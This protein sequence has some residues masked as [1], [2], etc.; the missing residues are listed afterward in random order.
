[1]GPL[2]CEFML[3]ILYRNLTSTFFCGTTR[4]T[5]QSGPPRPFPSRMW[6]WA[7]PFQNHTFEVTNDPAPMA[8]WS[9]THQH[10]PSPHERYGLTK[11]M[12]ISRHSISASSAVYPRTW[13]ANFASSQLRRIRVGQLRTLWNLLGQFDGLADGVRPGLDGA[14]DRCV[15]AAAVALAGDTGGARVSEML[16]AGGGGQRGLRPLTLPRTRQRTSGVA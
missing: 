11:S 10:V 2:L 6:F 12:K 14:L 5:S 1:M 9:S 13:T 8:S 4:A 16:R 3:L 7:T 15:R